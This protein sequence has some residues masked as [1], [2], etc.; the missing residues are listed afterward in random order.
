[1]QLLSASVELIFRIHLLS[2]SLKLHLRLQ[3]PV[4]D[5][6]DALLPIP[7]S[8]VQ[9]LCCALLRQQR[10][11]RGC[12]HGGLELLRGHLLHLG[13]VQQELRY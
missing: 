8:Q 2:S 12:L 7:Q 9:Q 4:Q 13:V 10:L 3:V 11:K 5:A 6:L 1:M